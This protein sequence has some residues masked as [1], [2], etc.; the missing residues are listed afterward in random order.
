MPRALVLLACLWLSSR[1]VAVDEA[2]GPNPEQPPLAAASTTEI[3]GTFSA[4]AT[5][6]S[7]GATITVTPKSPSAKALTLRIGDRTRFV[8]ADADASFADVHLGDR[9]SVAYVGD[10]AGVVT[11]DPAPARK[12][13][14]RK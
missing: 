4:C 8:V 11:V 13:A 14:H 9:V 3:E 12:H 10:E 5:P 2:P 1:V 6:L 7:G